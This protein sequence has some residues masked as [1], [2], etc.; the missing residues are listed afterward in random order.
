M[1]E[2]PVDG[3]WS[4]DSQSLYGIYLKLSRFESAANRKSIPEVWCFMSRTPPRFSRF[5]P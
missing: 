3:M 5:C 1:P 2:T 4:I